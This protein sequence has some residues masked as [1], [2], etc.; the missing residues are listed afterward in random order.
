MINPNAPVLI[1]PS[2]SQLDAAMLSW[3][4]LCNAMRNN[5]MV[6]MLNATGT[7]NPHST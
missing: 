3:G 4:S 2:A 7:D 6:R 5:R 1:G